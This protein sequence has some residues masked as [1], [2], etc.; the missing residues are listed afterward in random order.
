M[1][2]KPFPKQKCAPPAVSTAFSAFFNLNFTSRRKEAR[3]LWFSPQSG[4]AHD[5]L[6][7]K[8]LRVELWLS[9]FQRG[10]SGVSR[11]RQVLSGFK[12]GHFFSLD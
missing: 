1:F 10:A 12:E 8:L 6:S 9:S 2:Q 5:V 4:T 3:L 7:Y 11:M